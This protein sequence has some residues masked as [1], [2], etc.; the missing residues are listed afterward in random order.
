MSNTKGKEKKIVFR[1]GLLASKESEEP[2]LPEE[3]VEEQERKQEEAQKKLLTEGE[4]FDQYYRSIKQTGGVEKLEALALHIAGTPAV[5]P[6]LTPKEFEER[7]AIHQE[8][9]EVLA[10][11]IYQLAQQ[12]RAGDIDLYL[13][14]INVVVGDKSPKE[15][16][17]ILDKANEFFTEQ[18]YTA[19]R[20]RG[21]RPEIS[22]QIIKRVGH[23]NSETITRIA[24]GLDIEK[25]ADD[26]WE[27]YSGAYPDKN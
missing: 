17:M 19:I 4:V 3:I 21:E 20:D 24:E 1:R 14:A 9:A 15:A 7:E 12:Q 23:E 2:I 27:L 10:H 8:L 26:L 6:R 5:P 22:H 11:Q 25:V 16:R 18:Y 13:S